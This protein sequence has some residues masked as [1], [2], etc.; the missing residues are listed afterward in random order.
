MT[1]AVLGILG[2]IM[3]GA[4]SPGPSFVFVAR[5]AVGRTRADGVAA[6]LGMGI[7]GVV[8]ASLALVGLQALIGRFG[9]LYVGLKVVGGLYLLFLAIALWRNHGALPSA[10][11]GGEPERRHGRSFTL[12][13][14]TQLSNP[15]AAVVYGS[16]FAAFLPAAV[17]PW[18]AAVLL[19]GVF[20]IETGW[21]TLVAVALS[22]EKPRAAYLRWRR[23]VDRAAGTVLGILG[24]RLIADA[25]RPG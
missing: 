6:A 12:G 8:F 7:G 2:A 4:M 20:L 11:P 24:I 25:I 23:W 14:A 5:T 19:V 3:L 18:A 1:A 10:E 17:P 22:S 9:S 13:L 21:Y 16:I 15:K